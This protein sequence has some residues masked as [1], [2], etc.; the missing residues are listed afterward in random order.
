MGLW[1]H[2]FVVGES[3]GRCYG[4]PIVLQTFREICSGAVVDEA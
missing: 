3:S 1:G 4:G 2:E